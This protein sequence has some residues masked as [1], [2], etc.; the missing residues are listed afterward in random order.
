MT[1][2]QATASMAIRATMALAMAASCGAGDAL[3]S[4]P[5]PQQTLQTLL[6]THRSRID[7]VDGRLTGEA[8]TALLARAR[9]AQF[10]LVGEDHGFADV[11][12]FVLALDRALGTDSPPNLV[13]EIGPFAAQRLGD[14]V[15][16]GDIAAVAKSYPASAPFFDFVDD[17]AMAQRWVERGGAAETLWGIDQ[18]F[19]LAWLVSLDELLADAPAGKAR[20]LLQAHLA[21]A[22]AADRAMREQH[23]PSQVLLPAITDEQFAELRGALKPVED[24]RT[25]R[26]LTALAA[27]AQIYRLNNSDGFASNRERSLLMKRNFM[28]YYRAAQARGEALPRAMFRLGA[29]H[30]ARG[31]SGTAQFDIGNLASE[32][33]ASEGRDSLHILLIA[34]GGTVNRKLPFLAD[35]ALRSAPYDAKEELAI[36][37]ADVFLSR[38]LPAGWTVFDLEPLRR[39]RAAR[40]A[41]G[42]AFAQTVFAYDLVIVIPAGT[43]ARELVAP[44]IQ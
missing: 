17:A 33:A 2:T 34:A 12:Q 3:A 32:L 21:R 9:R 41:G 16:A 20:E 42:A 4:D 28:R 13:V 1:M 43:A 8:S 22:R 35:E 19:I 11:P 31:L 39:S 26:L 10:V 7:L 30:S 36:L 15:R 37:G 18:E 6:E 29:I 23:D 25:D 40:E 27:S 5:S 14:A 38:L 44:A 24:D